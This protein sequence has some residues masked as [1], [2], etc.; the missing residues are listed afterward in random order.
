MQKLIL[1][2]VL[3]LSLAL[4]ACSKA[5]QQK[6]D[7]DVNDAAAKVKS[8]VQEAAHSPEA[9][10]LGSEIKQAA[11]DAVQ[12]TKEAAKGAAQGAREGAAK[13][14]AKHNGGKDQ[15]T[16]DDAKK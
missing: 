11:G 4:A 15:A 2:S 1:A 7:A 9:K 13:V 6:T 10:K 3:G 14:E 16:D 8:D 12:V 5:E